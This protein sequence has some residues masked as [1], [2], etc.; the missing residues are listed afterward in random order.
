MSKP[1]FSVI[2]PS[3]NEEKYIGRLLNDILSQ[4][5]KDFEVIVS[6]AKST[7]KTVKVANEFKTKLDLKISLSNKKNLSHQRNVGAKEAKGDYF[8]F[9]DADN[10]IPSNFLK[11][12]KDFISK[13]DPELIIPKIKPENENLMN[14]IT[15]PPSM[16]L[17]KMFL[18]TPRPFSTGGNLIIKNSFFKKTKGFDE[19]VFV[20]EDHDMVR[21][22]H[23]KGGKIRYMQDSY[24]IFC[25]RRYNDEGISVY[26]KYAYAYLYQILF[27]RVKKKIYSYN[28]GG[29][30]YK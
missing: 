26:I 1:L 24:V 8:F 9:I 2:I 19:E 11:T 6:D 4:T 10:R 14:K 17:I 18:H 15:Y 20:G 29:H 21:Q 30:N 13:H 28:M 22:V 7:D 27:R 25:S 23:E 16:V 3:L 5:E 12:A